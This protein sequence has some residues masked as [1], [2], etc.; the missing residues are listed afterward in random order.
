[1]IGNTC[2]CARCKC[3]WWS[4]SPNDFEGI[5]RAEIG[6]WRLVADRAAPKDSGAPS[7]TPLWN[8]NGTEISDIGLPHKKCYNLFVQRDTKSATGETSPIENG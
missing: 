3:W 1:V 5:S 6:D 2:T 4:S 8:G 7:E